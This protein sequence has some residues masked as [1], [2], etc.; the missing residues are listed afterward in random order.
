MD[1]LER[2]LGAHSM[3]RRALL[4]AT[5]LTGVA[6]AA[7]KL[8]SG[9]GGPALA[10][11]RVASQD[12]P[13]DPAASPVK[14]APT[15][16]TP[17]KVE[18]ARRNVATYDWAAKLRDAAVEAARPFVEADDQWL[19]D[20][21]TT[22]GLPRS[23]AVNQDAGSPITGQA[24]YEY[25]NYPW[26]IDHLTL[27]WKLVD[28]SVPEDSDLP[29]IYPTND[30]A[31]FYR[32]GLDEHGRFDR[33]RADESLLVNELY[34][35][36]GPTWG[37]D[38]G[39]GWIDESGRKWTF[40]AYYNHWGV[41]HTGVLA[42]AITSLR[43]A[44]IYTG[45]PMYAHAGLI[46]LDRVAD[47]YPSMD[48]APYKREDGFLH[49]DGLSGNGRV[50]GCI[51]ETGLIRNWVMAYDAF[52]PAIAE[53]DV[54]NVVPFLSE[55]ARTYGLSPK[56]TPEQIR[57]NIENGIL[58]QVCAGVLDAKIFGNF[59]M[60]QNTLASAAV[61]LDDP[62]QSP[63]WI[64]FVFRSGGRVQDPD[65]RVTGGAFYQ[66]LVDLV[67]RDG[68][69]NEAAPHYNDLWIGHVQGVADV[70]AGYTR[71][72]DAD[73]YAH[74]KYAKM[75]QM[76][77][78]LAMLRRYQPE[79]GDSGQTGLFPL[80]GTASQHVAAFERFG[81]PEYAQLAYLAGDGDIDS[82]YSD[83]FALDVAGTQERI[84]DIIE[85]RGELSLPSENLTG[86]GLAALRDGAG[87]HER[88][89]WVYYGRTHGHGHRDALNLGLFG[90]GMSLLPDLGY[91]EFADNNARRHEWTSNTIAHNTVV[92]D[93]APQAT[94]WVGTP[95]GFAA[96][97]R[98]QY[99][100]IEAPQVYSQTSVYRR[101]VA[102]IRVD[103]QNSYLVDVFRV[104]G[105]HDH[106][107]SFHA[108]EGAATPEG[109]TLVGQP[110]YGRISFPWGTPS[111]TGQFGAL[112]QDITVEPADS[113][114]LSVR[115]WDDFDGPT[116]GYHTIQV[117]LDGQV[118][119]E[120][121]VATT[122]GW[123]ELTADVTDALAGKSKATLTLRLFEKRGVSNFGV[124][125]LFDEVRITGARIENPDF[126]DASSTAWRTETNAPRFTVSP[127]STGS[128]AGPTVEAP[129]ANAAP[130]AGASGFDWLVNVERDTAPPGAFRV[131]WSIVDTY[132][133]HETDPEAHVRL[134]AVHHADDVALCDGIP[135]RNKPG[136][137][138]KLRYVISHRTGDDLASQFVS[139][140]EPYRRTPY[141]R[142][143]REV[144]VKPISG[145]LAPH[146][147]TAVRVE[148]TDGRVDY[149]VS[150][151]RTDVALRVDGR[152]SFRGAF[153]VYSLRHGRAEYVLGHDTQLIGTEPAREGPAALVGT[154]RDFTR[155][156][157]DTNQLTV[158]LT[159]DVPEPAALVGSYVYVENDGER[160]A[161]YRI[162][163]ATATAGS[164]R[165]LVLDI[166]DVTT[167][168]GYVDPYDFDQGY[169]YDVASGAAVRIPLTREWTARA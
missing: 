109:L 137:P 101:A 50:V 56:D 133:V 18:A 49:S 110:A 48:T 11:T 115:V 66:T 55:Q 124:A 108:A 25:G 164:P 62:E 104:V 15:F 151:L 116:A 146:E 52:F 5:A 74:P 154:L 51:W 59:G 88:T 39:F 142:S 58:R 161:V 94:Q 79:I 125:V 99:V 155:E 126:E 95:K 28:P 83:V 17:E 157:S 103:E 122:S 162:H 78:R 9:F 22:Q 16:Y 119:A 168:R 46:L 102:Q 112:H 139:V 100:D 76:R 6:G 71:Y 29:R 160:N 34:P 114:Q 93:A 91:P 98:V 26:I 130:R 42:K 134:H 96:T 36:R 150:A 14:T 45:D 75:F 7:G 21:V 33:S 152:F 123:R 19:W 159:E 87:E 81:S 113:Y 20:L 32:S 86:Y 163:G 167:V 107:F 4:R 43:D 158:E 13:H 69:G 37:V 165:A 127:H 72:P 128:Y 169:R 8:L 1:R 140:I 24:I 144:P 145:S 44:Y 77:Y 73:L 41:W 27:P 149:V 53:S 156:L 138:K 68:A 89:A 153:G 135:P 60:H 40:I 166:G 64:D 23:Y 120:E 82:L 54:A 129:P 57:L 131:D 143:V 90:F 105:G 136:N 106:Y 30:F 84:R 70:L 35:E 61:V 47:V 118:V 121:D 2:C 67:D 97:E 117:L 111:T 148:L 147:A 63:A 65:Y 10:A 141:I 85:T 92:V 132:R 38:D 3:S 12:I 31:A 80:A